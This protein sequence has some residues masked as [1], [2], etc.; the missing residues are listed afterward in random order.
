MLTQGE[1]V[2]I[3]GM[4]VP[5]NRVLGI[6]RVPPKGF[7]PAGGTLS[8]QTP[9]M[10][11]Y[12]ILDAI[13]KKLR[14]LGY[15]PMVFDFEKPT[16]RDFSKTIKTLV[17]LSRFIIADITNP[18]SSPLELQATMPDYMVPYVPI[19]HAKSRSP[20][21]KTSNRNMVIGDLMYCSTIPLTI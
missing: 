16:Q 12:P 13:R 2:P 10:E 14:E 3:F 11:A 9:N 6:S 17:G 21:F 1:A 7:L 5:S 19:I 18:K 20:C 4:V 15:L 8:N